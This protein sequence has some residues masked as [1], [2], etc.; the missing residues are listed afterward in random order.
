MV[1]NLKQ[2]ESDK[3]KTKDEIELQQIR[4][5]WVSAT[6]ARCQTERGWVRVCL[7][8]DKQHETHI[9]SFFCD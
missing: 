8:W 3:F 9:V 7:L 4:T 6:I 2:R 5:S 1:M